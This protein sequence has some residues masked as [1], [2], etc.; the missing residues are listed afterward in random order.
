M[1]WH[2]GGPRLFANL[3]KVQMTCFHLRSLGY[4]CLTPSAR[5]FGLSGA[6][7]HPDI[8]T[9]GFDLWKQFAT[10]RERERERKCGWGGCGCGG[11]VATVA[12][13]MQDAMHMHTVAACCVN[14]CSLQD[15]SMEVS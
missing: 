13:A 15:H 6:S 8:V 5:D 1:P 7:T 2:F 4:S 14:C 10:E 12:G 3:G 11:C 9:W